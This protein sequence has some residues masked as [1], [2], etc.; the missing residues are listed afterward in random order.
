MS[1]LP[2]KADIDR[3]QLYARAIDCNEYDRDA[4]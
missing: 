1:A 3:R 2:A 4:K